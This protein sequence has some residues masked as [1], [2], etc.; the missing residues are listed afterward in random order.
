MK[1]RWIMAAASAVLSAGVLASC[2]TTQ[3][4]NTGGSSASVKTETVDLHKGEARSPLTG[5]W[6]DKKLAAQRPMAFMMSNDIGAQP[7]Y[8]IHYADVVYEAPMEGDETR[9][10][11]VMQDYKHIKELMPSRSARHYFIYWARGLDA[12]Y[13]HYGQSW[14]AKRELGT[15]DDLN[16]MDGDL[17]GVTYFRDSSRRAPHNAYTNGTG[18]M[19][20]VQK[21]GYRTKHKKSF[22]NGF[23]FNEDD[24]KDVVLTSGKK[25]KVVD[26]GYK[27]ASAYFVYNSKKK[28][29][30][31]FEW[32]A[33]HIDALTGKQ[34]TAKN[35]IIQY[36]D[37]SVADSVHGYL[38]VENTGKGT[39][40]YMTGGRYEK[41]TWKKNKK[42][43][44][45]YYY[46]KDG[47]EITLNQGRTWICAVKKSSKSD[48]GLYN[49]VK[50]FQ[51]ARA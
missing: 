51:E 31:R 50:A 27:R 3:N 18:L 42:D 23:Q 49:S 46:D 24:S 4:T 44:P 30:K 19:K 47:N 7:Q 43:S 2:G 6:I 37:W 48:L 41:I 12:I 29:Y 32:N 39:G 38:N 28:V 17:A 13:S 26:P 25:A 10:M 8:G 16:G 45:T 33:K 21:R 5:K 40:Y 20:G 11:L 35:I 34:I 1:K 14:L 9:F 22:K 36:C 15:I